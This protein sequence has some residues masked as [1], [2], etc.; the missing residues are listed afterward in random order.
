[1]GLAPYAETFASLG[2]ATVVFDYRR[3][4]ASS[5]PFL[6]QYVLVCLHVNDQLGLLDMSSMYPNNSKTTVRPSSTVDSNLSSIH[7]R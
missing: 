1:M 2:Y 6:R 3:W 5:K 7:T 4:G